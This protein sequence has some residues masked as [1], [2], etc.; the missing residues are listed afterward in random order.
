MYVKCGTVEVKLFI[1]AS[2]TN[3]EIFGGITGISIH[4]VISEILARVTSV[5][6][7]TLR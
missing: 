3:R 6:R 2:C 1:G 5:S 4:S 7:A